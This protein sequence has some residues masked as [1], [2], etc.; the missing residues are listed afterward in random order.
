MWGGNTSRRLKA[1]L[2]ANPRTSERG[3]RRDA[4]R[5]KHDD[6]AHLEGYGEEAPRR[7]AKRICADGRRF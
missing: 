4:S 1:A 3:R 5:A 6:E 7:A 2:R